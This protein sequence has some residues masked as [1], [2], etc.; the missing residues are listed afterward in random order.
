M[1]ISISTEGN[2]PELK[3]TQQLQQ[4]R[5]VNVST[6]IIVYLYNITYM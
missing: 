2:L 1:I 5:N 3:L 4:L 6:R